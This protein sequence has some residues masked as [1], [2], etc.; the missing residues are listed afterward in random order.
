MKGGGKMPGKKR[1]VT[2]TE[3]L[4]ALGILALGMG[5]ALHVFFSV[6]GAQRKSLLR[7]QAIT[8]AQALLDRNLYYLRMNTIVKRTSPDRWGRLYN[9]STSDYRVDEG[10]FSPALYAHFTQLPA[11]FPYTGDN[12]T[13]YYYHFDIRPITDPNFLYYDTQ[14]LRITVYVTVPPLNPYA[15]GWGMF[16]HACSN[17]YPNCAT[18]ERNAI[19]RGYIIVLST[20]VNQR[21]LATYL[22]DQ[23]PLTAG[24]QRAE[25]GNTMLLVRN[26]GIFSAFFTGDDTLGNPDMDYTH[27]Y[28]LPL[29]GTYQTN[30]TGHDDIDDKANYN[31]I[32]APV[33]AGAQLPIWVG[34]TVVPTF[35]NWGIGTFEFTEVPSYYDVTINATADR[36]DLTAQP[37]P[38][39][40]DDANWLYKSPSQ[41]EGNDGIH[42]WYETSWWEKLQVIGYGKVPF[43]AYNYAFIQV[44][45][46]RRDAI[47]KNQE[48][49]YFP[50]QPYQMIKSYMFLRLNYP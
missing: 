13:Q 33:N 8:I 49:V 4:V 2:L 38:Y 43:G 17:P 27:P 41:P 31:A 45:N 32:V 5:A 3:I 16:A 50:Y 28:Q 21:Y 39:S 6:F 20:Y 11:N 44:K 24:W 1:G 40:D 12:F 10:D 34:P 7:N 35:S 22:I 42:P 30:F 47:R 46:L 26:Y 14:G 36:F 15:Q 48:G 9:S 29:T 23:D 19:N 18:C 37:A 25:I